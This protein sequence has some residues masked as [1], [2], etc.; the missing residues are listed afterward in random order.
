MLNLLSF[1]QVIDEQIT[2]IKNTSEL[3]LRN[4]SIRFAICVISSINS[5]CIYLYGI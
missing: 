3:L 1:V 4:L 2:I 5:S